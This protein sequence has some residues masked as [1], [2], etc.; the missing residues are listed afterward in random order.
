MT[1]KDLREILDRIPDKY[2][3]CKIHSE[4]G[5]LYMYYNNCP[6][7]VFSGNTQKLILDQLEIF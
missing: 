5:C 7:T 3:D 4:Y 1:I 6:W 2:D